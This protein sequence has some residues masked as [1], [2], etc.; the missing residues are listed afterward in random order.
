MEWQWWLAI[1]VLAAIAALA[2]AWRPL[3]RLGGE[4]QEERARELFFL[5][6]ERLEAHFLPAASATGKPRGL[7]WKECAFEP[8]VVFARDRSSRQCVAL[9]SLTIQF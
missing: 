6:R 1:L 4:I 8:A 7:R 9:V 3:R 5:Q 2:L